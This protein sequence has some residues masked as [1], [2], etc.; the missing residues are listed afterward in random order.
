MANIIADTRKKVRTLLKEI[1]GKHFTEIVHEVDNTFVIRRGSAAVQVNVKPL[2]KEDC[3]V[4][5]LSYVV[6]GAKV[7]PKLLTY[8]MRHNATMP[9]GAFGLLFDDT[10]T[11]SHTITGGNLDKNELRTTIGTVAFVADETDDTIIKM[12]GGQRAVDANI[13]FLN[14]DGVAVS[15]KKN[16]KRKSKPVAKKQVVAK[17]RK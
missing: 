5:A 1:Y 9:I 15:L 14:A 4:Q 13:S 17:K 10:V 8:L 12:A 11:F 3:L 16:T 2:S 6:Q 7:G